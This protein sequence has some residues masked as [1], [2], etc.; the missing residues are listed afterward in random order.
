MMRAFHIFLCLGWG[1]LGLASAYAQRQPDT[2]SILV[3]P[4]VDQ[5]EYRNYRL[6]K[7][8]KRRARDF[9]SLRLQRRADQHY[10]LFWYEGNGEPSIRL[11][12]DSVIAAAQAQVEHIGQFRLQTW[13]T[14]QQALDQ[15][16]QPRVSLTTLQGD[17]FQARAVG[18]VGSALR[19]RTDFGVLVLPLEDLA[20]L[21][22]LDP[23][24]AP[25]NRFY[26]FPN[27]SASRYLFAP[28]AIPLRQGEG[29]YQNVFFTVNSINY[30]FTD[31]L[32]LTAG[33]ELIS[34][35]SSVF[36]R[37]LS[38][39]PAFTNVKVAR[40]FAKNFYAG[41]GVLAAGA[42]GMDYAIGG[43]LAYGI[44][45]Y[46]DREKNVTLG[47]GWY[48]LGGSERD[49]YLNRAPVITVGGMARISRRIG[50][51]SENWIVPRVHPNY[52]N[53]LGYLGTVMAFSAGARILTP[54]VSFDLALVMAGE[55]YQDGSADFTPF[56]LPF[57]GL[58]YRFQR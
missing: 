37:D 49:G 5:R 39:L 1:L 54:Q 21:S 11:A 24:S 22:R 50:L 36:V 55:A 26:G 41:G 51:V 13:R 31:R 57:L 20:Q 6:S 7:F 25:K 15:G 56:P 42:V 4:T 3:G 27:P 43:A 35:L 38:F 48:G 58:V 44:A 52:R 28:S 17:Y 12:R 45:T 2:L 46:G 53:V 29:Y 19:F 34:W 10:T 47:L 33:T 16:E 23:T 14:I 32:A 40:P 8:L 9:D 18:R 30:G